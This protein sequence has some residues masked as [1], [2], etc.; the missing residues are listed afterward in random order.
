MTRDC[1][2]LLTGKP[3]VI[4][5]SAKIR[6][7]ERDLATTRPSTVFWTRISR[8]AKDRKSGRHAFARIDAR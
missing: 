4:V 8:G 3:E 5:K 1:S 6:Q 7:R 2:G